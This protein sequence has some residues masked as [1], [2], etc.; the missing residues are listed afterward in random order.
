MFAQENDVHINGPAFAINV[1]TVRA[2]IDP[3]PRTTVLWRP[4]W[5][6]SLRVLLTTSIR[7]LMKVSELIF[8]EKIYVV[9]Q[10][11]EYLFE[12]WFHQS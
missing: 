7:I 5:V 8:I 11:R 3:C 6:I 1:A 9:K 4:T 12:L 2:V 10:N